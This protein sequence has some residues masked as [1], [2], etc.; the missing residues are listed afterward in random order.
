MLG[1]PVVRLEKFEAGRRQVFLSTEAITRFFKVSL[2]LP[3][4]LTKLVA[5]I[6][7]QNGSAIQS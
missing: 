1:N 4:H 7:A 5:W 6:V 2:R 3:L